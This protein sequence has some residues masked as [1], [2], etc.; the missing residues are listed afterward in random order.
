MS[1]TCRS[2]PASF[3]LVY[4]RGGN[5]FSS[6]LTLNNF[7]INYGVGSGSSNLEVELLWN[8]C[9]NYSSQPPAQ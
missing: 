3:S 5:P 1:T 8:G 7:N 2:A 9:G 6:N 4:A